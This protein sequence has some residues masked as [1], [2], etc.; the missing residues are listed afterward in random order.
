MSFAFTIKAKK[1]AARAGEIKTTHGVIKTPA[2]MPVGTRGSVRALSSQDLLEAKAQ[3]ILGNTYHLHLRPGEQTVK[4]LG[5]LHDFMHWPRPVL[6]DSG[7]FQ[8]FSLGAE[9]GKLSTIDEDGATFK[10]HIDGSTHRLTPESSIKIQQALGADIIMAFDECTPIKGKR[11]VKEAMDRTHRWLV[12]CKKEWQKKPGNQALFGIIQGGNYKDLRQDSA[13]FIADQDL[14]GIAIG[15][16]S[17]GYFMDQTVEHISWVKAKIPEDKPF[18]AMG[19]GRDPQDIVAMALAGADIFDC[20]APTRLARN[21]ALYHGKLVGSS[22]K[23][24]SADQ[25]HFESEFNSKGR[26]QI[27]NSQ[28]KTDKRVIQEGCDC[29]TCR[30]GYSRAYL[31][32][33]YKAKEL[34]FYRLASI[35]NVRFMIRLCEELRSKIAA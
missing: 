33:L 6:T 29:M 25:I 5:G 27:G 23:V 4:K 20:V 17:V 13:A 22:F 1:C 24:G 32:H 7:G 8:V 14:P 21:G 2:Y 16:V 18:Y 30:A 26:L 3:I 28:F 11:Y 12:R 15:G 10:S 9:A 31:H 35:H 19:V 34:L